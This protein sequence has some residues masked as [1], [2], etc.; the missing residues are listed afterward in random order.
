MN[1]GT[2][3]QL[4]DVF[5]ELQKSRLEQEINAKLNVNKTKTS[6]R[7]KKAK[8][9]ISQKREAAYRNMW[10]ETGT[11]E[12]FNFS[13]KKAAIVTMCVC[14]VVLTLVS[15]NYIFAGTEEKEPIVETSSIEFEINDSAINLTQIVSENA[16]MVEAKDY[17]KEEREIPFETVY[18]EDTSLQKDEQVE[19]Q[20]GTNGKEEVTLI[21]TYENSIQIAQ[22]LQCI[23]SNLK[24]CD[25]IL[26][27]NRG[28]LDSCCTRLGKYSAIRKRR[29]SYDKEDLMYPAR[30]DAS[31]C[32]RT[33]RGQEHP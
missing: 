32:R 21:K 26:S 18:L 30:S 27:I 5:K 12:I 8:E 10:N 19:A 3:R 4:P 33:G 2:S 17:V 22:Y 24:G 11:T 20:P 23:Y 31:V 16:T 28:E 13:V 6:E 1:N 9:K 7:R 29:N 25:I 15:K 14:G